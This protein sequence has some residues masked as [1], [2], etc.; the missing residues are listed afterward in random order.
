MPSPRHPAPTSPRTEPVRPES[1][2]IRA[3]DAPVAQ[4]TVPGSLERSRV[5]D[6]D[7]QLRARIPE[8]GK[9]AELSLLLEID[10]SRQ[11]SRS[12][13]AGVKG[14]IDTLDY[15]CRLRIEPGRDTRLRAK[16]S[17]RN[18]ALVE[19]QLSAVEAV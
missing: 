15:H 3:F 9:P 7:L 1:W 16:A 2:S 18:C 5:F 6:I 4:L 11:W 8:N 14:E 17:L 12:V 19:I 13:P 10:G